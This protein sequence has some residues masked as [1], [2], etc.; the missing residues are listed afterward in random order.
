[1][2]LPEEKRIKE[3]IK[4]DRETREIADDY[5]NPFEIQKRYSLSDYERML[6]ERKKDMEKNIYEQEKQA[7][8][9]SREDD[10]GRVI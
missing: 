2:L 1:M 7:V 5:L 4:L 10:T 6:E 3:F 8:N 9:D